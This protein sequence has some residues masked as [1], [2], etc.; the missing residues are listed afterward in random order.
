MKKIY[1]IQELISTLKAQRKAKKLSQLE[2]AAKI[3]APQSYISKIESGTVNLTLAST[4]E[5]ARTLGLE[6]MLIPRNKMLV[7]E[8]ILAAKIPGENIQRPAYIPD[9]GDEDE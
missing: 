4:V 6:L 7:V 8:G 2:L 9:K 5:I 3:D 1:A